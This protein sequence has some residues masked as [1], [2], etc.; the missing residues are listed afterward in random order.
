MV[1]QLPTVRYSPRYRIHWIYEF[2]CACNLIMRDSWIDE[3]HMS[4]SWLCSLFLS[5]SFSLGSSDRSH[6][7]ALATMQMP[8]R[9]NPDV[10]MASSKR[11]R[12]EGTHN[13][14]AATTMTSRRDEEERAQQ[15][16]QQDRPERQDGSPNTD[17]AIERMES[18][19]TAEE[20]SPAGVGVGVPRP[21]VA[22]LGGGQ[23]RRA[24]CRRKLRRSC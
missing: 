24:S 18:Q 15:R 19:R 21:R 4:A 2:I 16:Q 9:S 7:D 11:E 23:R 22:A 3:V 20:R 8:R 17:D 12:G 1:C 13:P 5:H 6:N 14:I 10:E